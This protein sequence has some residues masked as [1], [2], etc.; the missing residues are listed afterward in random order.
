[1]LQ[2]GATP[3]TRATQA[4]VASAERSIVADRV[5]PD[6]DPERR[7]TWRLRADLPAVVAAL[8]DR[9]LAAPDGW[10]R[11][12]RDADARARS[13]IDAAMDAWH[14]PSEPRVARDVA[15]AVPDG[16]TLLVGNSTPIRD[17]DLAMAP[18][19][20]IRVL[21][22]R[23]ASGIDG[24]ASTAIG[25][26][27]ASRAPTT[28]LL[29]DLSAIHDLGALAWNAGRADL[30]L[31]IVVIDNGGGQIFSLLP[32]PRPPEHRRLFV[33][34]PGLRLP[35]AFAGLGLPASRV[36]DPRELAPR[37]ERRRRNGVELLVVPVSADPDRERR[38]EL[39]RRVAA[40]L[41]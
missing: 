32:P 11:S 39:R 12:W 37:I 15:A 23:G 21:A 4:F 40:A 2:L 17:L 10:L 20:G 3:T 1:V 30:D 38:E 35:E 7:A 31:T 26:A 22:N 13:A 9:D 14:E 29:G 33:T 18:R 24:L 16:G 41:G 19:E 25:V 28:A 5:H 34:P 6:P 8:E 36:D 27:S